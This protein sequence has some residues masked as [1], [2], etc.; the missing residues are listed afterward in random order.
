MQHFLDVTRVNWD[1]RAIREGHP[2]LWTMD[3]RLTD[4]RHLRF[5]SFEREEPLEWDS[6]ATHVTMDRPITATTTFE[7][8]HGLGEIVTAL[9][10]VGLT[11]TMLVE[12]DSVP[13]EALPGQMIER[14]G[15][16]RDA[17]IQATRGDQQCPQH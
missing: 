11:L 10:E 3:E 6:D 4:D 16:R 15:W 12:H 9:L 1:D 13:W 14:A 17:L 5:S 7:W 8:N 2:I